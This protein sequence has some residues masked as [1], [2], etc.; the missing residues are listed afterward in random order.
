[1]DTHG[2]SGLSCPWIDIEPLSSSGYLLLGECPRYLSG[3]PDSWV[4]QWSGPCCQVLPTIPEADPDIPGTHQPLASTFSNSP[5]PCFYTL[6]KHIVNFLMNRGIAA[7]FLKNLA[8]FISD[9]TII[10]KKWVLGYCLERMELN[11]I[12]LVHQWLK[13][14]SFPL[15]KV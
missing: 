3:C 9:K 11:V 6:E 4:G 10:I 14:S 5:L 7:S 1:M 15:S 8:W 2:C 12:F 13:Q